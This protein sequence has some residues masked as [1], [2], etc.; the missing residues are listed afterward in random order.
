M[1]LKVKEHYQ[2]DTFNKFSLNLK[3]DAVGSSFGFALYFDP[4]NFFH[5]ELFQ[6]SHYHECDIIH[7][8]ELLIRGFMLNHNFNLSSKKSLSPISGYSLSG[9]L[10]DCQIPPDLYPLQSDGQTLKQI[11]D[12]LVSNF[13]CGIQVDPSVS[14]KVNSVYE[15]TTASETQ[16]I[17]DY[18]S[19]L[20]SQKN[21]ILSHTPN[22]DLLFTQAKTNKT[23]IAHFN[24]DQPAI[25]MSLSFN[26]KGMHS[27]I[28]VQKQASSDGGNAGEVTI[29]N[30]YVPFVYRPLV[31]TQN[32]GSD[33][34]TNEAA[35]NALSEE[36][37]GIKLTIKTSMWEIDGKVIKPNNIITV[38]SKELYLYGKSRWFIE[39]VQ[40]N[41]DERSTTATLTC[42]LPGVYNNESVVNVFRRKGD[43]IHNGLYDA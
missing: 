2:I 8:G 34:D 30:P 24:G 4:D 20:A 11:A 33:V 22:G 14:S 9:V 19:S 27:H 41:G 29:R 13:P 3:Y 40:L 26:G 43:H 16:T 10:E 38:E 1:I 42:V 39:S 17:K 35:R 7:N 15:K 32:S 31:K 21:V 18:L 6:P 25:E 37:K 5:R 36:L 23:P 28:T 12:K